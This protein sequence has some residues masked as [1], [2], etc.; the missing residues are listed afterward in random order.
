MSQNYDD[1]SD[2]S[3][4]GKDG[5]KKS[6]PFTKREIKF[7]H[8]GVSQFGMGSW[9]KIL[10]EFNFQE[11]RTAVSCRKKFLYTQDNPPRTFESES[12]DDSYPQPK[13]SKKPIPFNRQ[14]IQWVWEGV[15]VH[16]TNWRKILKSYTFQPGRTAKSLEHKYYRHI[17]KNPPKKDLLQSDSKPSG[18]FSDDECKYLLEGVAKYGPDSWE[19]ILK[20]YAFEDGRTSKDLKEKH[21]FLEAQRSASLANGGIND[22]IVSMG[23]GNIPNGL[24]GIGSLGS[25]GMNNV[26]ES[27]TTPVGLIPLVGN[28]SFIPSYGNHIPMSVRSPEDPK[29]SGPGLLG[30][31][32][33]P[34]S[35][36]NPTPITPLSPY[37]DGN[38]MTSFSG[39]SHNLNSIRNEVGNIIQEDQK[40]LSE[41]IDDLSDYE[42]DY[43]EYDPSPSTIIPNNGSTVPIFSNFSILGGTVGSGVPLQINP[44][45]SQFSPYITQ[46]EGMH[47]TQG[48][49]T[50]QMQPSS[51]FHSHVIEE[52]DDYEMADS[53]M[54]FMN[55]RTILMI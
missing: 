40:F 4:R 24:G 15:Q 11:G 22:S 27:N 54:G 32:H 17:K 53:D 52:E 19:Q 13:R 20:E 31:P 44:T 55:Q 51:T 5:K 34:Y 7:L 6:L 21:E 23:G 18:R 37:D 36:R 35:M 8:K 45:I 1:D 33:D 50:N 16:G 43:E 26:I 42:S 3:D 29:N 28:N 9:E 30:E 46:F 48:Y 49:M 10:K 41:Q 12:D 39:S 38:M 47:P 14:E 25:I 2:S